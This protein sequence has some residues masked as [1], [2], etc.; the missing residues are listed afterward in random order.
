MKIVLFANSE[1][2]RIGGREIVVHY[3]AKTFQQ[4]GHQVRV[5][6]PA[7]WWTKRHTKFPYPVHRWPTLRGCFKDQV[8]F[9]QLMLDT[10][11]FGADVIHAHGTIPPGFAACQVKHFKKLPVILTPHGEDINIVP[12]LDYGLRLNP[13]K[14]PKIRYAVEHADILTAISSNIKDSLLDTGANPGKIVMI[15]NG[16]DAERYANIVNTD[17]HERLH[18][19]KD[20]KIILSVGN[21]HHR[22][23]YESL[24]DAMHRILRAEP[25]A[26]LIIAGRDQNQTLA[27]LINHHKLYDKVIYTGTIPLPKK[28]MGISLN[29]KSVEND[30]DLL[31]ALYQSADI[32]VSSGMSDGAEGLSLAVLDALT[33]KLPVVASNI[34]GNK[35]IVKDGESGIIVEPGNPHEMAEAVIYLLRNKEIAKKYG[36]I[37]YE[38]SRQ[39]HWNSVAEKYIE[40]YYK[41]MDLQKKSA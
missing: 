1:L 15:P 9:S 38:I 21:Y 13:E 7:G 28:I 18:L 37:A 4:M 22:K 2:P 36:K 31:A 11:I 16:T 25:K 29:N 34:S 6:G 14:E 10:L 17:I 26:R 40:V 3:L 27:G 12:E 32:Y 19:E 39:Y 5:T 8:Y 33:A 41:A 30:E 23:G 20:A 24:L 35:D